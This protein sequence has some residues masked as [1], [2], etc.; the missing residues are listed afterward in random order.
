MLILLIVYIVLF[1][2]FSILYI[3]F[4]S[5]R[6]N[7]IKTKKK[8]KFPEFFMII[9]KLIPSLLIIVF[10]I[11]LIPEVNVLFI[12]LPV[13]FFFCLIGDF[14]M[15]LYKVVGT[16]SYGIS[17]I[18]FSIAYFL[19]LI[20]T[21]NEIIAKKLGIIIFSIVLL[22]IIIAVNIFIAKYL[23]TSELTEKLLRLGSIRLIYAIL[24]SMHL[25]IASILT[26]NLFLL[27][28][29]IIVISI[30]ALLLFI[31]DNII[32]VR[33]FHHMPSRS[34][35][36]IMTTYYLALLSISLLTRFYVV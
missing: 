28:P 17:N 11:L 6:T 9:S 32:M 16:I 4:E 15:E 26:F 31:S 1:L 7:E 13:A 21:K 2:L 18:L 22:L 36:K 34:V 33:E 27:M 12:L 20:N 30:G 3:I 10:S 5:I 29:G 19:E 24:V 23:W 35:I 8:P 25:F 14:C